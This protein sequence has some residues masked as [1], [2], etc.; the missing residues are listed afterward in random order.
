VS[1]RQIGDGLICAAAR[2]PEMGQ[3]VS[4]D[5]WA[6][7]RSNDSPPAGPPG[8][9]TETVARGLPPGPSGGDGPRAALQRGGMAGNTADSPRQVDHTQD[10]PFEWRARQEKTVKAE[11]ARAT[12]GLADAYGPERYHVQAHMAHTAARHG[13]GGGDGA[14]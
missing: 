1:T 12:A 14:R 2:P 10:M 5:E 6:A 7:V 4:H 3:G 8:K 13:Q 11:L 9:R